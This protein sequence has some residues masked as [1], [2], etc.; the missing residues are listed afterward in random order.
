MNENINNI[1]SYIAWFNHEF[2]FG[3]RKSNIIIGRNMA[4]KN[5]YKYI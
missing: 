2:S 1:G 3:S 5:V 4:Q